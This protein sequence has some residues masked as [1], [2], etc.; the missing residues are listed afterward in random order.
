MVHRIA[1]NLRRA[2]YET[3][4]V[5]LLVGGHVVDAHTLDGDKVARLHVAALPYNP[6]TTFAEL[7]PE[8]VVAHDLFRGQ[9]RHGDVFCGNVR[10][11]SVRRERARGA[12]DVQFG[13]ASSSMTPLA[14]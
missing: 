8:L 11:F 6:K 5:N 12:A 2:G 10:A 1:I 3:G 14:S 9:G 4:R 13:A 7:L